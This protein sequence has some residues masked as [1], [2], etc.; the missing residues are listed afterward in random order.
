[1][2]PDNTFWWNIDAHGSRFDLDQ[3]QKDLEKGQGRRVDLPLPLN[4]KSPE[5]VLTPNQSSENGRLHRADRLASG[6]ER[7][8]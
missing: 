4:S 2:T 8:G 3:L 5:Y 6:R 1:M 7:D